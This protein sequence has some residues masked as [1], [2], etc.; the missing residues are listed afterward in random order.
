MKHVCIH[1]H[2]F[3]CAAAHVELTCNGQGSSAAI[4]AQRAVKQVFKHSAVK[5][6]RVHSFK[7]TFIV[8]ELKQENAK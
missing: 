6:R 1:A 2:A 7:A 3:D 4:A 5:G 8:S